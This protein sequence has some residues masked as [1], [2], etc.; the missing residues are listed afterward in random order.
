M[1]ISGH[2]YLYTSLTLPSIVFNAYQLFLTKIIMILFSARMMILV[3][4]VTS[5]GL[6]RSDFLNI[7]ELTKFP[8]ILLI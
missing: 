1:E 2:C 8:F 5:K 6:L 4:Y 7:E 3:T